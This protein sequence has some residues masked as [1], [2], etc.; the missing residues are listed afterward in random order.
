MG[1]KG[2][3]EPCLAPLGHQETLGVSASG[4]GTKKARKLTEMSSWQESR[5]RRRGSKSLAPPL[6]YWRYKYRSEMLR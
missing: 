3:G 6:F 1:E 4:Q 5:V 2:E